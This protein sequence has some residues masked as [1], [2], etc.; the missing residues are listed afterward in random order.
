[1]K[2]VLV[3][4]LFINLMIYAQEKQKLLGIVSFKSS[5]YIYI[6]FS[7]T[8]GINSDDTLYNPKD[9]PVGLVKFKSS[10]SVAAKSLKN[11]EVGDTVFAIIIVSPKSSQDISISDTVSFITKDSIVKVKTDISQDFR[12]YYSL[13]M[14]LQS[15]GDLKNYSSTNRLRYSFNYTSEKFFVDNLNFSTYFILTT[16]KNL[17]TPK[18]ELKNYIKIYELSFNYIFQENHNIRFGRSLNPDL[19]STG[20]IDGIQYSYKFRQNKFGIFLGSRPDYFTYWFNG[21]LVQGGILLSRVDSISNKSIENTIAFVEQTNQLKTDRRFIYFQ[22]R[23]DLFPNSYF[24][25]STEFDFFLINKGNISKKINLTSLNALLTV[26]PFRQLNFNISYDSRKN[27]YYI[28]SFKNTI[29]TL[30]E[31]ALRQGLRISAFIRPI[32]FLL[33]NLQFGT[34]ETPKDQSASNNYG[35]TVGFNYLPIIY[36]S[37]SFGFNKIQTPFITGTNYSSYFSK[38]LF[39]DLTLTLNFRLYEF[40][41]ISTNRL[42]IDRF[43]EFG[44]YLNIF[45]NLSLSFTFEQKLNNEKSTYLM[46][47]LTNRF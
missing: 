47:D 31:K 2:R 14:S 46:L 23:N 15:Y 33:I 34:R 25:F 11:L 18:G 12:R 24:F 37:L 4:L 43:I 27:V 20:S 19:F 26:R 10:T 45:R 44:S 21:K 32:N 38:N 8:E 30:F 7:S 3:F 28:E 5:Q 39:N 1:M 29:D 9:F 17:S 22:H 13:R 16:H 41:Q 42:F 6:K 40:R 35:A 36:S